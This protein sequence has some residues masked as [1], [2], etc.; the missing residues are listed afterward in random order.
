MDRQPVQSSNVASIAYD[1]ELQLLEV[2]FRSGGVYRYHAV[3]PDEYAALLASE[4]KGRYVA[5]LIVPL[6]TMSKV[7]G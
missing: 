7:E 1:P 5:R 6:H 2:E 4:S 3:S